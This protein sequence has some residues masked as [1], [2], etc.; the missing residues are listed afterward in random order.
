MNNQAGVVGSAGKVG[1]WRIL[2]VTVFMFFVPAAVLFAAAGTLR[3]PTAWAYLGLTALFG[4]VSRILA[5]QKNPDLLTERAEGLGKEDTADWDKVLMPLT[6]I[7]GPM[8]MLMVAGLD[9]RFSW[10]EPV[11]ACLMVAALLVVILGCLV[12]T[13]A[14]VV[15]RYFSAVVRIQQDRGQTV[16]DVGPYRAVRHPGYAGA[17]AAY[18]ATPFLLGALWALVPVFVIIGLI[19]VRTSLE[20]RTLRR[21]LPGY[22]EYT[23]RVRYRLFPGVW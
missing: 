17:V 9:K 12:G 15:N 22:A 21:E 7:A 8:V 20:D 18:L 5:L 3:W 16:V 1:M 11:P 2:V 4:L 6:A 23:R 14:T 13:G 10:S 19:V